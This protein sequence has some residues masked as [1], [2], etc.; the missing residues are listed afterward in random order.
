MPDMVRLVAG[1]AGLVI[2]VAIMTSP[3]AWA[4]AAPDTVTR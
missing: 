4:Q 3:A 2:A 1:V